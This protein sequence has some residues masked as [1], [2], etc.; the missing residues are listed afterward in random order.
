MRVGADKVFI[1]RPSPAGIPGRET[2]TAG[3]PT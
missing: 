3:N 1:C 2:V